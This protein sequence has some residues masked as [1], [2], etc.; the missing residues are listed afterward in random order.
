M[1]RRDREPADGWGLWRR[2]EA[3]LEQWLVP[4]NQQ[5]PYQLSLS[6]VICIG[7]DARAEPKPQPLHRDGWGFVMDLQQR[8][9]PEIS[10]MCA[11]L[12]T[13]PAPHPRALLTLAAA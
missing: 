2:E 12:T 9:E 3:E 1:I 5:F 6:Q 7:P 8:I 11:T 10:T 13:A 4:G